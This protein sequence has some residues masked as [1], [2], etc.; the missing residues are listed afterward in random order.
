MNE[1]VNCELEKAGIYFLIRMTHVFLSS[2]VPIKQTKFVSAESINDEWF[3]VLW[4]MELVGLNEKNIPGKINAQVNKNTYINPLQ[5]LLN[6][7]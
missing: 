1:Q 4:W 5:W 7:S 3:L 6:K 2:F